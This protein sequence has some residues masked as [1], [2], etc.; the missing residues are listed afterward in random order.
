MQSARYA[1]RRVGLNLRR[2]DGYD[3]S[4][5]FIATFIDDHLRLHTANLA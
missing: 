3:H 4:S 5:F 2:Q 1:S